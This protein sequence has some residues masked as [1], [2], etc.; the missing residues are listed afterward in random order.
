VQQLSVAL[1]YQ[2]LVYST[3]V[4]QTPLFKNRLAAVFALF[5]LYRTLKSFLGSFLNS[6]RLMEWRFSL[7]HD[8]GN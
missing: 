2:E 7:T 1:S 4:T 3:D 6:V 8:K 5:L